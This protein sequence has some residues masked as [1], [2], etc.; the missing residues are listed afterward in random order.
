MLRERIIDGIGRFGRRSC[1]GFTLTEM[2]IVLV[3]I[4]ILAAIAYPS[5]LESAYKTRR[6]DGLTTL[7]REAQAMERC[8][9]RFH[10]YDNADA[11]CTGR[12]PLNSPEGYYVIDLQAVAD[13][14]YVL[15]ARPPAGGA[16][17]GDDVNGTACDG[18]ITLNQAGQR[19]PAA[20]W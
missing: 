19:A 16:Q 14:T 7:L 9:S 5:Y 10:E 12:Y 8:F 6:K 11:N 17:I 3:I 15:E 18:G 13:T 4:S 1:R 20:C 2:L